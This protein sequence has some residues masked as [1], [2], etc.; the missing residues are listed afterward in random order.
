MARN[1]QF[2]GISEIN[3]DGYGG[4]TMDSVYYADKNERYVISIFKKID[5]E[6]SK[7]PEDWSTTGFSFKAAVEGS[8]SRGKVTKKEVPGEKIK[9][10]HHSKKTGS[11][12]TE[13]AK[14]SHVKKQL[15]EAFEDPYTDILMDV[16]NKFGEVTE[17]I[18]CARRKEQKKEDQKMEEGGLDKLV[19]CLKEDHGE[20]CDCEEYIKGVCEYYDSLDLSHIFPLTI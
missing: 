14:D 4:F 20:E 3:E 18:A 15:D 9:E 19:K 8:S 12:Q 6:P 7:E 11:R 17:R 1:K 2:R 10:V 13:K 16:T 5:P